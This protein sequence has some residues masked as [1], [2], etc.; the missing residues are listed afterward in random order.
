MPR[1]T[2]SCPETSSH[3][4]ISHGADQNCAATTDVERSY[5]L[6][7]SKLHASGTDERNQSD[8][9]DCGKKR[10]VTFETNRSIIPE[11]TTGVIESAGE[12]Y[13]SFTEIDENMAGNSNDLEDDDLDLMTSPFEPAEKLKANSN[14]DVWLSKETVTQ[15]KTAS[16]SEFS[17][18]FDIERLLD[19]NTAEKED[20]HLEDDMKAVDANEGNVD[21]VSHSNDGEE[22][23][24]STEVER[25]RTVNGIQVYI[26]NNGQPPFCKVSIMSLEY[27]LSLDITDS[28]E[29]QIY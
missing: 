15:T 8:N 1:S 17:S 20:M 25:P 22:N 14:D 12:K 3:I 9:G 16:S 18:S 26:I 21:P 23:S 11:N 29:Y 10:K 2:K 5:N 27:R 6:S 13:Q 7:V 4:L 19:N 24:R 28:T